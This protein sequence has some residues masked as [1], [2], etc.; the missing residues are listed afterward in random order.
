MALI[1][2][3]CDVDFILIL[4]ND[5]TANITIIDRVLDWHIKYHNNNNLSMDELVEYFILVKPNN[6]IYNEMTNMIIQVSNAELEKFNVRN[7]ILF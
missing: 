5:L 7:F 3:S 6:N 1:V 2:S 4:K